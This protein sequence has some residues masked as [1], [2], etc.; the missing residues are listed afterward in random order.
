MNPEVAKVT[1]ERSIGTYPSHVVETRLEG[2]AVAKKSVKTTSGSVVLL[3]HANPEAF[4]GQHQR[5]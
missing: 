5:R 2:N 1:P 3:Q 4:L